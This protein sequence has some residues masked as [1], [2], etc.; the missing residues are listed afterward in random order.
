MSIVVPIERLGF[1]GGRGPAVAI[2]RSRR[3]FSLHFL[4]EGVVILRFA[5]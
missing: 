5:W 4:D 1:V 3:L 2:Q